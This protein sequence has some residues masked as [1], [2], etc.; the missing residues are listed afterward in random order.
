MGKERRM[1]VVVVV[2]VVVAVVEVLD[3]QEWGTGAV[4]AVEEVS[5]LRRWI[6]III[7]TMGLMIP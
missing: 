6:R 7:M 4:V 3:G 5:M 1:G 2:V